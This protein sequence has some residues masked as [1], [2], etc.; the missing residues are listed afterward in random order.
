[1][2][3]SARSRLPLLMALALLSLAVRWLVAF[4]LDAWHAEPAY[5]EIGYAARAQGAYEALLGD[6]GRPA[7]RIWYGRGRWPP[8]HPLLLAPGAAFGVAG[9]RGMATVLGALGTV[10]VALWGHALAG[11]RGLLLAGLTHALL[12]AWVFYGVSLWSESSFLV[13]GSA[14]LLAALRSLTEPGSRWPLLGGLALGLALCVRATAVPWLLFVPLMVWLRGQRRDALT[15]LGVSLLVW[16]PWLLALA[17]EQ[18]RLVPGSTL[19]GYN[20]WLGAFPEAPTDNG[21]AW[22][23]PDAKVAAHLAMREADSGLLAAQQWMG[24]PLEQ[25]AR[26]SARSGLLVTTDFFPARHLVGGALVL[27]PA[28]AARLATVSLLSGLWLGPLALG[29]ALVQRD[30]TTRWLMLLCLAPAL[31]ALMT[32]GVPRLALPSLLWL[33]PLALGAR[34]RRGSLAA[35]LVLAT[36]LAALP[37]ALARHVR[38]THHRRAALLA[39]WP[40]AWVAPALDRVALRREEPDEDIV[41]GV[42]VGA[43]RRPGMAS[44][45][46]VTWP[47]LLEGIELELSGGA[48]ELVLTVDGEPRLLTCTGD[49][50][51]LAPDLEARCQR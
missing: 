15:W 22:G 32:V 1:M 30:R 34:P 38:P 29:G 47:A 8:L 43:V 33:L 20:A 41:L 17:W 42:P 26:T 14:V 12:P 24:A 21:G 10:A 35:L 45:A 28:L 25:L 37:G 49:W 31:P 2:S 11:R 5:D 16:S 4:W 3:T 39:A 18:G 27:S 7:F 48:E 36:G 9:L 6:G 46:T 51:P 23:L 19:G 40:D 13:F 50:Q 44:G